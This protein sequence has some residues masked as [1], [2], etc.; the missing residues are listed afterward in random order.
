ML[1]TKKKLK[2]NKIR[3]VWKAQTF[4]EQANAKR[5]AKR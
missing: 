2:E 3:K 4:T 1:G 5:G